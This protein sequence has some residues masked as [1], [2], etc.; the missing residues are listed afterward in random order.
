MYKLTHA[1]GTKLK[2]KE[3]KKCKLSKDWE[4]DKES[5]NDN[6]YLARWIKKIDVVAT[7]VI[8]SHAHDSP[9]EGGFTMMI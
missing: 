3:V 9:M 2:T 7:T 1:P 8:L 6:A 5:E 4:W